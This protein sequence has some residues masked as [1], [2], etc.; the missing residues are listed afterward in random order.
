[1]SAIV[2]D[3][4]NGYTTAERPTFLAYIPETYA[5]EAFFSVQD[6]DG[7]QHY[8]ATV[9]LPETPGVVSFSMPEEA[10]ALEVGQTYHWFVVALCNQ[11][12][13]PDSPLAIGSVQR[14][15]RDAVPAGTT[16]EEV[17]ALAEAGIWYD[18]VAALAQLR[19]SQPENTAVSAAWQELLSSVELDAIAAAPLAR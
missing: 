16:L 3:I 9:P 7:N 11:K 4:S 1:M 8:Q 13:E 10:P 19:Q 17:E 15:D 14:T 5:E 2:P 6:D 12:L 18:T